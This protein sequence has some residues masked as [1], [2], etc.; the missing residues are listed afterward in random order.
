L[1][2]GREG[3]AEAANGTSAERAESANG[4]AAEEAETTEGLNGAERWEP[5]AF[6]R[7]RAATLSTVSASPSA[8]SAAS[9]AV[10]AEL[11]VGLVS[12]GCPKNLV[13]SEVMLGQLQRR[14]HELVADPRQADVIVVNTCAFFDRA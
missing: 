11:K 4:Q 9:A 14:G 10:S 13:D 5:V 12:L 3:S 6:H 1:R 7:T 8:L 2:N